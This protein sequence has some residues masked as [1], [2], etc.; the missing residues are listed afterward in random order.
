MYSFMQVGH[1]HSF[2][3]LLKPDRITEAEDTSVIT[4]LQAKAGL[5]QLFS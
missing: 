1:V 5:L 4:V 3:G 2:A